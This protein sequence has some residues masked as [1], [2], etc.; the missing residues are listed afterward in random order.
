MAL[1][2]FIYVLN[3]GEKNDDF[4]QGHRHRT[5]GHPWGGGGGKGHVIKHETDMRIPSKFHESRFCF[6]T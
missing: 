6:Q 3:D 1:S 2:L 5:C 4:A